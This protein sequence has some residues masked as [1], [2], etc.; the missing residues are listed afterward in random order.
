MENAFE[1]YPG[2]VLVRIGTPRRDGGTGRED[3]NQ[4]RTPVGPPGFSASERN[5]V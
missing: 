4:W 2:N 5:L 3:R 1:S